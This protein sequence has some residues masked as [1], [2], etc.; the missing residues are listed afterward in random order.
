MAS[1][2]PP[3]PRIQLSFR[4]TKEVAERFKNAVDHLRGAPLWLNFDLAAETALE[5]YAVH[6]ENTYNKKQRY[7]PAQKEP[8]R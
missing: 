7:T 2:H 5:N 8:R 6:L 4:I 1:K 3:I